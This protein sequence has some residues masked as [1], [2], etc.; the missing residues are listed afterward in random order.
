METIWGVVNI[1]YA[2]LLLGSS[3]VIGTDLSE[4]AACYVASFSYPHRKQHSVA[5]CS[6]V[7]CPLCVQ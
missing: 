7:Y 3:S 4:I 6:V 2:V 1:E 5:Q